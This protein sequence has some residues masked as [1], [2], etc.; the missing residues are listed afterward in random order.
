MKLKKFWLAAMLAAL[1]T[2]QGFALKVDFSGITDPTAV[3]LVNQYVNDYTGALDPMFGAMAN[4][5]AVGNASQPIF[6]KPNQTFAIGFNMGIGFSDMEFDEGKA[7]GDVLNESVFEAPGVGNI[8]AL[9]IG[10]AA[11]PYLTLSLDPLA[12]IFGLDY[13]ENS[14]LTVKVF[15][16]KLGQSGDEIS[17]DLFSFGLVFRK[18]FIEEITLV[19]VLFSVT[20]VSYSAGIFYSSNKLTSK[21]DLGIPEETVDYGGIG[22]VGFAANDVDLNMTIKSFTLD[23]DIKGFVNVLYLFDLYA[24]LGLSIN[25]SNSVDVSGKFNGTISA[26]DNTDTLIESSAQGLTVSGAGEGSVF[27]PRFMFGTQ[28]NLWVLKIGAQ[29][30]VALAKDTIKNISIGMSVAF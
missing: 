25:L 12:G 30:S 16:L 14:D 6:G 8:N 1:F 5:F 28:I 21:I 11:A 29:Y 26:Y 4:S 2:A 17:A 24:G 15:S 22:S 19:P 20:G 18:Q 7:G 27:V 10:I 9:T 3:N 23:G 13:F